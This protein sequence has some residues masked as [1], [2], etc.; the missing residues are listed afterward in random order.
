MGFRFY[1]SV[2]IFPGVRLN[3]SKS[4]VSTTIGRPGANVNIRGRRVRGTVGL[5][6]SGMSYSKEIALPLGEPD[7]QPAPSPRRTLGA[8]LIRRLFGR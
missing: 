1:K 7:A 6:G 5:P 3:F 4:G 8:R 2:R